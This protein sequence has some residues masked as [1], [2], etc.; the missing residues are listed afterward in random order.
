MCV[1]RTN[2]GG[3]MINIK[4]VSDSLD[5]YKS[6]DTTI[7]NSGIIFR[8]PKEMGEGTVEILG[9]VDKA[10]I[11]K[12][13]YSLN[14]PNIIRVYNTEKIIAL[15]EIHG[16]PLEYYAR[17]DEILTIDKGVICTIQ[18]VPTLLYS[19]FPPNLNIASVGIMIRESFIDEID[20][21]NEDNVFDKLAYLLND[22][23][24]YSPEIL[25]I[26]KLAATV[27]PNDEIDFSLIDTMI[28]NVVELL[29]QQMNIRKN[30]D[31]DLT[32]HL[33]IIHKVKKYID[34][35]FV[36]SPSVDEL[37][38]MFFINKNILQTGFKRIA[39]LSVRDY[40][41]YQKVNKSFELLA[42]TDLRIDV[43]AKEVGYES[44]SSFYS[45][46]KKVLGVTPADFRKHVES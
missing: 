41:V 23:K 40:I 16:D 10:F 24:L 37:C 11:V 43:I 12:T 25:R 32:Y 7:T 20:L 45:A 28:E 36:N 26:L 31:T 4:T 39:G 1:N 38:K 13:N 14:E 44:K 27:S 17:K 46:F 8:C 42:S 15:A 29:I 35:N 19:Q 3:S 6:W 21:F 33:E 2:I 30:E 22:T 5:F 9:N 34:E 18:S